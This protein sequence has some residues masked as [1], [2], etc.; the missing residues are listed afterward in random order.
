LTQTTH[1]KGLNGIR[2]L[3]ALIVLIGHSYGI[4]QGFGILNYG[5][6]PIFHKGT[7]AVEYFFILSGFLLTYLAQAELQKTGTLHIRHFF[8]RRILRILPLYYA[9]VVAN[10]L[11]FGAVIPLI[12]G[13]YHLAY[14]VSEGLFY[15]LCLLPNFII[16]KYPT[17]FGSL[18]A[19]WSIGVEEQFYLFF[20]FLMP[21]LLRQKNALFLV[22]SLTIG[23]FLAYFYWANAVFSPN[24]ATLQLFLQTLKFQ[25]MFLGAAT[26]VLFVRYEARIRALT[27]F[28]IVHAFVW[29][30]FLYI[31]C[32]CPESIDSHFGVG[33]VFCTL[34]LTVTTHPSR[35]LSLDWQPLRYLGGLSYGIYMYHS[36][37]ND[38]LNVLLL[39]QPFLLVYLK[40]QPLLYFFVVLLLTCCVAHFSFRYFENYFLR[41]KVKFGT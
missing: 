6:Q 5:T 23:Y 25:F 13:K 29:C 8:L 2:F 18:Y 9:V 40:N 26:A 20:P 16:A 15:H 19:L 1:L 39:R 31:V 35:F 17:S 10:Y 11:L 24:Y 27:R 36:T 37:I 41:L 21:F 7:L 28:K 12:T 3:L 22:I 38:F 33:L 30:A 32:V 34:L 14:S 4:L